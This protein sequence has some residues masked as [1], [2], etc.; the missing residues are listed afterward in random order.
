MKTFSKL[1]SHILFILILSLVFQARAQELEVSDVLK[2]I[3]Q[4]ALVLMEKGD[5]PGLSRALIYK[6][7]VILK[8]YGFKDKEEQDKVTSET[9]FQLGSTTKA[10]TAMAVAKLV[11]EGK[12]DLSAYVSDIIPWFKVYFE[13]QEKRITVEQLLHHTSG[14]PW[15]SISLIPEAN[16]PDALLKTVQSINGIEL[17][18][19]PGE[20]YHYAT[21]NYDILA[22]IISEITG[23]EFEKFTETQILKPLE[24]TYSSFGDP[25]NPEK[26]SS[27]FKL[28]FFK[29]REY[30]APVYK[31]N[32]AAGYLITNANDM[33]KWLKFQMGQTS[34]PLYPLAKWTHQR[35]TTVALH[36]M[37]SYAGGWEIALDGTGEIFHGGMN[38]NYGSFIAFRK[39]AGLGVAVLAN[40]SSNYTSLIANRTM[41]IMS[42]EELAAY[43]DPGDNNDK[44]ISVLFLVL[45]LYSIIVIA[46]MSLVLSD[47]IKG[48]R[49]AKMPQGKDLLKMFTTAICLIP[50]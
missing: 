44:S 8:S 26:M 38:P 11:D 15:S 32:N 21:I 33:A 12:L 43:P 10:F 45:I 41:K 30:V 27:G 31:G 48:K 49:K 29:A 16:G 4:E 7:Q 39:E 19:L 3:D 23:T 34:S 20:E 6:D 25:V 24:M 18:H 22:L 46:L 37:A 2:Q 1:F 47:V 9:L 40:S 14:I 42:G 17:K 13:D 36:N 28:S 35:D 50:F 5:I